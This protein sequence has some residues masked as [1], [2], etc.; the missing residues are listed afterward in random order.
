[1]VQQDGSF[2][3]SP[4]T[5]RIAVSRWRRF[6]REAMNSAYGQDLVEPHWWSRA[7]CLLLVTNFSMI[8]RRDR[9]SESLYLTSLVTKL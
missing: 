3:T 4:L 8:T 1:M 5:E 7:T 2:D 6:R 9:L